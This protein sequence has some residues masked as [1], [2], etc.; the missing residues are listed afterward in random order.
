MVQWKTPGSPWALKSIRGPRDHERALT[1][2][3]IRSQVG[4]GWRPSVSSLAGSDVGNFA[5]G[6]GPRQTVLTRLLS[7]VSRLPARKSPAAGISHSRAE[8]YH[9]APYP[10]DPSIGRTGQVEMCHGMHTALDGCYGIIRRK[11]NACLPQ[12]TNEYAQLLGR[13]RERDRAGKTGRAGRSKAGERLAGFF[14]D[15][16][17]PRRTRAIIFPPQERSTGN[18]PA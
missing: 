7:K 1:I 15:M 3:R 16:S 8:D 13:A 12:E 10:V 11:G 18:V 5:S 9:A 6:R 2:S 17:L 14:F 4:R